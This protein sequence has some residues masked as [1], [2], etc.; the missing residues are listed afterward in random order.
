[1]KFIGSH[2]TSLSD[3]TPVTSSAREERCLRMG[4]WIG[5][6]SGAAMG[7][8][9]I[10]WSATGVSGIHGSLGENLMTGIPS[11][12]VGGY[13]GLRTTE[14][15]TKKIMQGN[16]DTGKAAFRGLVY[17]ALDGAITLTASMAPLLIMGYYTETIRFN[18][19]K[20]P[21]IPW[22]I[23]TACTG[24]IIYGGTFGS[25]AGVVY[26]SGI[27]LYMRF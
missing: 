8:L 12:L 17:G 10:Y 13:V 1:M 22:L 3:A 20:H 25:L 27:S 2:A 18:R 9:H 24:G 16:P 15:A 21:V 19:I 4:Q 23:V 7:F 14:W 6:I 5:A 11:I 26:G